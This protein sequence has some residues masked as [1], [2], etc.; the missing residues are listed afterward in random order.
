MIDETYRDE[1]KNGVRMST[2]LSLLSK[3]TPPDVLLRGLEMLLLTGMPEAVL[4]PILVFCLAVFS[5]EH[6]PAMTAPLT[7]LI[8]YCAREREELIGKLIIPTFIDVLLDRKRTFQVLG[9][10]LSFFE[11]ASGISDRL[12]EEM[13]Q[14]GFMRLCYVYFDPLI[15]R[16][17]TPAERQER[18]KYEPPLNGEMLQ[19]HAGLLRIVN[20]LCALLPDIVE[21]AFGDGGIVRLMLSLT[22][23]LRA[24]RLSSTRKNPQLEERLRT[25]EDLAMCV[26][27]RLTRMIPR[28]MMVVFQQPDTQ[29]EFIGTFLSAIYDCV[30]Y[31]A[32]CALTSLFA[33][34][35]ADEELV[36]CILSVS[37]PSDEYEH[38]FVFAAAQRALAMVDDEAAAKEPGNDWLND[39]VISGEKTL[40]PASI[41][42]MAVNVRIRSRRD[43]HASVYNLLLAVD[44]T[45]PFF[46]NEK[47][48]SVC[49]LIGLLCQ[50]HNILEAG[51]RF[52]L[53]L[54][55]MLWYLTQLERHAVA[56]CR[57]GGLILFTQLL[58]S[59]VQSLPTFADAVIGTLQMVSRHPSLRQ[60]F[61]STNDLP[62]TMLR[63][64]M[65]NRLPERAL[66]MLLDTMLLMLNDIEADHRAQLQPLAPWLRA[67]LVPSQMYTEM[68]PHLSATTRMLLEALTFIDPDDL[69]ITAAHVTA[70]G[71]RLPAGLVS[72][73]SLSYLIG[74]PLAGFQEDSINLVEAVDDAYANMLLASAPGWVHEDPA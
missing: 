12:C 30:H 40:L 64:A 1:V 10:I 25:N 55:A 34:L 29:E 56:F 59:C 21:A 54:C 63:V 33:F 22:R 19:L 58:P 57:A 39:I 43:L 20:R 53:P 48:T 13:L 44:I 9:Q 51:E 11:D 61:F 62:S 14:S 50:S 8:F 69:V 7:Q 74:Q 2:L 36:P 17:E 67:R 27:A 38:G 68:T 52:A 15:P 70:A 72:A 18:L 6:P 23:S 3:K 42:P 65:S 46:V 41:D 66:A 47:Q 49:Q 24:L 73:T 60:H 45:G 71:A 31:P 5:D 16:D 35:S 28:D 4:H 32:L 26:V 37:D